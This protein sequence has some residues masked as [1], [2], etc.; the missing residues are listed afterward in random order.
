MGASPPDSALLQD[1]LTIPFFNLLGNKTLNLQKSL[2]SPGMQ[3][4]LGV[5]PAYW[6]PLGNLVGVVGNHE[7]DKGKDELLLRLFGGNYAAVI[8]KAIIRAAPFL[9]APGKGLISRSW[10]PTLSPTTPETAGTQA[11]SAPPP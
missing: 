7:F 4:K 5:G 8:P 10:L 9:R 1:E 6:N 3:A 2:L 11:H